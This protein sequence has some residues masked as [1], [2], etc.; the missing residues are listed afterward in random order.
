MP[1]YLLNSGEAFLG[2]RLL[3]GLPEGF[4]PEWEI[5]KIPVYL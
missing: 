4:F 3:A 2:E 5:V 1:I